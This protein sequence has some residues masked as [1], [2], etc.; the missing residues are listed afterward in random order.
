MAIDFSQYLEIINFKIYI[1]F[2]IL[3]FFISS[4]IFGEKF[5]SSKKVKL[6]LSIFTTIIIPYP[7][8]FLIISILDVIEQFF[9]GIILGTILNILF[10]AIQISGNIIS[11]KSGF[12]FLILLV[13]IL[14]ITIVLFRIY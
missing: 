9:I 2:R 14:I 4:P 6:F 13:Y 5:I 12:S 11:I 10:I 8:E 1:F 3:G 7:D